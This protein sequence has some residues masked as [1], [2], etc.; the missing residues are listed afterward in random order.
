MKNYTTSHLMT[1]LLAVAFAGTG[2]SSCWHRIEELPAASSVLV[3]TDAVTG[4]PVNDFFLVTIYQESPE[5]RV[6]VP[7]HAT[8]G[9]YRPIRAE[10][11]RMNSGDTLKQEA[12]TRK[13]WMTKDG[14]FSRFHAVYHYVFKE[15]YQS[16]SGLNGHTFVAWAEA[17]KPFQFKVERETPGNWESD[18]TVMLYVNA[19]LEKAIPLIDPS[20]KHRNDF[21]ALLK[22]QVER[23]MAAGQYK[24]QYASVRPVKEILAQL[25]SE[26]PNE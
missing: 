4:E 8:V 11:T 18:L 7:A 2:C 5:E 17:R 16:S 19:M 25:E 9:I 23:V 12:L 22:Q 26:L 3:V 1:L 20:H 13:Q 6:D 14:L 24:D 15:G 21:L 10:I